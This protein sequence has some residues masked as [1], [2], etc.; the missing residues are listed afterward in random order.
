MIK[1]KFEFYI[2]VLKEGN[3]VASTLT[4]GKQVNSTEELVKKVTPLCRQSGITTSSDGWHADG[5]ISKMAARERH[6]PEHQLMLHAL[7][8]S[9]LQSCR[10]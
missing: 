8:A 4:T 5:A 9:T 2:H 6:L 3:T 7:T 10:R 1:I